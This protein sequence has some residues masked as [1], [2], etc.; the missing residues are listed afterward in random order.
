MHPKI[1]SFVDCPIQSRLQSVVG[2]H[3][4]YVERNKIN[5]PSPEMG[6]TKL[7]LNRV[8]NNNNIELN[9][10]LMGDGQLMITAY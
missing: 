6:K 4:F 3:S 2:M 5:M 8:H 9:F 1:H 10:M 7:P